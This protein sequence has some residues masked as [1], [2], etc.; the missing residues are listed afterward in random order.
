MD[1]CQNVNYTSEV[2]GCSANYTR[3]KQ[4]GWFLS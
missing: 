4:V 1:Q 2:K 3:E